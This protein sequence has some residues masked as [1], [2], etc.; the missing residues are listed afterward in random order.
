MTLSCDAGGNPTPTFSWTIGGAAVNTTANPRISVS[1]DNK[2]LTITKVNRSDSEQYRC[3]ANNSIGDAVT[4]VT[5]DVQC[6]CSP[7]YFC[8]LYFNF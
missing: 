1:S 2:Q 6:E 3:V 5:L 7:F 4:S 8:T